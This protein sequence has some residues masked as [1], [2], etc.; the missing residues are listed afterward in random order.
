MFATP[1]EASMLWLDRSRCN[2]LQIK[3]VGERLQG[4]RAIRVQR[5]HAWSEHLP[6]DLP[7]DG[8][9]TFVKCQDIGGD[10]DPQELLSG[11]VSV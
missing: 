11:G 2:T 9:Q 6:V 1:P 7:V 10:S 3:G 8:S 5:V 4:G